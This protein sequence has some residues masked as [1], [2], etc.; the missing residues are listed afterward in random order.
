MGVIPGPGGSGEVY[1]TKTANAKGCDERGPHLGGHF[2][3]IF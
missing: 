1:S 2:L 3:G